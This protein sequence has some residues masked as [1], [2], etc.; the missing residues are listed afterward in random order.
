VAPARPVIAALSATS[1]P[2]KKT[3]TITLT[4][5]ALTDA[6]AVTLGGARATFA[7]VSGSTLTV[8]FPAKA[9]GAYDVL[10][11]TPGGT[12]EKATFT[13]TR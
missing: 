10:V 4:G 9:A 6:S 3:I 5:T 13:F 1:G 8:T 2:E 12:S 7:K 11:T